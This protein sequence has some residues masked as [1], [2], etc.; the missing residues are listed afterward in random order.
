MELYQICGIS[1]IHALHA[2]VYTL[3]QAISIILFHN[4]IVLYVVQKNSVGKKFLLMVST[5]VN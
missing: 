2:Y 5:D 3:G 1:Y 4:V